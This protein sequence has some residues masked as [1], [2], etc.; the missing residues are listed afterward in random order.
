MIRLKVGRD[1]VLSY[2]LEIEPFCGCKNL[3]KYL[4][5]IIAI[6]LLTINISAQITET[7]PQYDVEFAEEL[8]A[9]GAT[10]EIFASLTDKTK[11][12]E[13]NP[14]IKFNWTVSR[15]E[16]IGGQGTPRIKVQ[17]PDDNETITV[18][19]VISGYSTDISHLR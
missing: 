9:K 17:T 8:F 7:P 10:V 1:A 6:V 19:V 3:M 16:I 13:I 18:T 11:Q 15:G 4:F 14:N 2:H 5:L 12:L